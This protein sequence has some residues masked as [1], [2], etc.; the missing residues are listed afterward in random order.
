MALGLMWAIFKRF[1]LLRI[2]TTEDPKANKEGGT[3]KTGG[4]G[5]GYTKGTTGKTALMSWVNASVS[6]YE[7]VKKVYQFCTSA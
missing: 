4:K 6:K 7:G 1:S 2:G 3:A 5:E